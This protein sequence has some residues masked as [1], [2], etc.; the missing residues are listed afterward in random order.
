MSGVR[1]TLPDYAEASTFSHPDVSQAARLLSLS[2]WAKTKNRTARTANAR[3]AA[4]Q[5]FLDQV[6][7]DR[8]LPPEERAHLANEAR[9][10]YY[11][12]LAAKG[13]AARRAKRGVAA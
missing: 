7:P 6:D 1:Q 10:N 4:D 5:R 8:V 12:E 13:V 3:K 11:R 2:S 9:K